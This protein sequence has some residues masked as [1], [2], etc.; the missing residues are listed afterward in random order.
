M[1]TEHAMEIPPSALAGLQVDAAQRRSAVQL[2][3]AEAL[4]GKDG[5]LSEA[6]R[7]A[8][9]QALQWWREQQVTAAGHVQE[10]TARLGR[11]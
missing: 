11:P 4:L 3:K 6:E 5:P 10:I 8:L 2:A 7:Q 1:N 9:G